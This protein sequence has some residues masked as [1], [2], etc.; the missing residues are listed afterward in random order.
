MKEYI[1]PQVKLI[2]AS[3]SVVAN[4]PNKATC[5]EFAA[6]L[7][8]D[9]FDEGEIEMQEYF[10]VIYLNRQNKPIGIHTVAMGGMSGTTV[11]LKVLFTGALLAHASSIIVCHNHPSGNL[12]TS[13][14]DDELTN[15]IRRAGKILGISLLDHIIL[16][17][18]GYL[19]YRDEI[20]L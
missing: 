6:S 10:K 14:Q 17:A 18:D 3:D 19:S 7:F 5:P 8:R 4:F 9:S 11:D 15:N 20:K 16:T 2:Y 1:I 13:P 12:N